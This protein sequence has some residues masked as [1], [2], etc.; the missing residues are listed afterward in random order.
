M[1][2]VQCPAAHRRE[3]ASLTKLI[4]QVQ[5]VVDADAHRHM[6][7]PIATVNE[8]KASCF[9]SFEANGYRSTCYFYKILF[10]CSY[11]SV[12]FN[13]AQYPLLGL[14]R[15]RNFVNV[16]TNSRNRNDSVYT[17]LPY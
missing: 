15:L 11:F 9:F 7:F 10:T 2:L 12:Y 14:P 1:D 5:L 3:L 4:H 16:Y 13:V 17:Q 6:T 8:W